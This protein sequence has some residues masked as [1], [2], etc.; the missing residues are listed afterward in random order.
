MDLWHEECTPRI[1]GAM[2]YSRW[3]AG[4]DSNDALP[5][6]AHPTWSSGVQ[7]PVGQRRVQSPGPSLCGRKLPMRPGL[8]MP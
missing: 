8:G 1:G 7:V 4:N 3:M 2:E 6:S 5:S